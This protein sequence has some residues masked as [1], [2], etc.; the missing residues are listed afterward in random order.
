MKIVFGIS[1]YKDPA[2]LKRLI[3]SLQGEKRFFCVH[4]DKKSNLNF[5]NELN[6]FPQCHILKTRYSVQW[7]G[8]NQVKYQILFLRKML[9]I[10]ENKNDR[11]FI[12]TGQDYPL[13]S[14]QQIEQSCYEDPN[15]IWMR[16]LNLTQMTSPSHM[17][18]FLT[19]PHYFRDVNFH[20][21]KMRHYITGGQ[22]ELFLRLLPRIRKDYLVIDG[23]KWNIWQSS[24]YFSCNREVAEYIINTIEK[25]PQ[26][27]SYFKHSFVPEELTIPTIIFN[28]KYKDYAEV[29]PRQQYEGLSTLAT[30]HEFYYSGSI[31]VYREDDFDH[32]INSNKMFCRKVETGISEKLLDLI[33][34]R[35]N[36]E[37]NI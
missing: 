12:I 17:K 23:N 13:W 29:F 1:V 37:K 36:E 15:K 27:E 31:K 25:Y 19:V 5:E 10:S 9:E 24:G 21:Q 26:I 18:R 11:L 32:L 7:G 4:I 33:D 6:E 20:S 34:K 8:W 22:R 16:G 30:L 2:H 3:G 14:N 35:R 28:S